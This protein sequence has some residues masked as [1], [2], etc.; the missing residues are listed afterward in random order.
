[1]SAKKKIV[2]NV[3][4]VV[5]ESTTPA[6][7]ASVN[8]IPSSVSAPPAGWVA[9]TKL[10]RRGRRPKNGLTL[11]APDLADEFRKNAQALLEELGPNAVDPQQLA[12]ALDAAIAWEGVDAKAATFR[13]YARS[14]RG[15][16][17]D[18]AVKLMAG[19]QAGVR[20]AVSRDATFA[21]RF[22]GVA[23]AFA[24]T[25]R[26]KKATATAVTPVTPA[27]ETP[28]TETATKA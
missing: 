25:R 15:T 13:T 14:Q 11:V 24:P 21:D 5:T 6:V 16:S 8:P 17:W 1:M 10:G 18:A 4:P 3:A 23:K 22:P 12:A 20:Y 19:M 2:S 9:P 28:A 26:S 27:S 7:V